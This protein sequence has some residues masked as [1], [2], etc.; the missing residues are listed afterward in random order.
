MNRRKILTRGGSAVILASAGYL[1]FLHQWEDGGKTQHTVYADR[2][3]GGLPTGCGGV[4]KH[5]SPYPVVVGDIWSQARCDEVAVLVATKTQLRL[6]DC[7]TGRVTQNA[8]D[9]LSSHSHNFGVGA[10]CASRA[11]GLINAGRLA[12]GCWSLSQ[13]EDGTP[14]WSYIRQPDGSDRFVQGLLNRRRAE[15]ALCL[16][17]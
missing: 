8:F 5:T 1:G 10:T 13:R 3:A 12:E 2:L 9:A 7:L 11:V 6:A 17:P 15:T 14:N 16:K 4:T